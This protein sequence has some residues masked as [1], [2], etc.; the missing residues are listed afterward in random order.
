MSD[1]LLFTPGPL[2]TSESVKR[3]M[4]RDLGSRDEAFIEAVREVRQKLLALTGLSQS[5]GYEAVLMQGSGTF[6][7]ESVVGST[8]PKGGKLL[9]IINGAYGRRIAQ[10]AE[11]LGID[12]VKLNTNENELPDLARIEALLE[13]DPEITNVFIVHCETTTGILNP[14]EKV[15]QLVKQY[16][17]T[18]CVDA[19]S[20]FGAIPTD[21]E[22][23]C[24]DFLVSSAN[25]CIEGV[26]GFSFIIAKKDSLL[27]TKGHAR[28]LSFNLLAQ[29]KGLEANGQFRFT[30]PTHAILAF[31]KAILELEEEG[32][33]SGRAARYKTNNERLL[34]GMEA[35]G[36]ETYLDPHLQGYI[37]TSFYYPESANFNFEQ[38]YNRLSN[39][40]LVI[41]PGKLT[42][43]DCFRVG[44][45][46]QIYGEDID[47]LL[48]AVREVLDEMEVALPVS[49]TVAG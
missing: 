20:S 11:V 35:L 26:P 13:D 49:N 27:A 7:I 14:V 48:V 6:G 46:G 39:K 37:I 41:Y 32:G 10:M 24:I 42:Q 8:V 21:I 43:A 4:L 18:Y 34:K 22:A 9:V 28:S 23:S 2:S 30:P 38:F 47:R 12:T 36:F 17:K 33:V 45:I 25:K 31:H 44:N 40:G 29:W 19:M 5:Q 1:K 15:G 3:T 16:G